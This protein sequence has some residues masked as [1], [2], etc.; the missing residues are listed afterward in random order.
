L[1]RLLTESNAVDFGV[2]VAVLL[3]VAAFWHQVFLAS[4]FCM[5]AVHNTDTIDLFLSNF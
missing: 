1:E 5:Q 4:G 2:F 3:T